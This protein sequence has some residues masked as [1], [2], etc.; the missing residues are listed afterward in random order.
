MGAPPSFDP[1]ENKLL[2]SLSGQ[3]LFSL[4]KLI[5]DIS[6]HINPAS[7]GSWFEH[8]HTCG[9]PLAKSFPP[10]PGNASVLDENHQQFLLLNGTKTPKIPLRTFQTILRAIRRYPSRICTTCSTCSIRLR[11]HTQ[12]VCQTCLVFATT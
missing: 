3:Q 7:A 1:M 11:I 10:V 8:C 4:T 9:C 6:Q 5:S 2:G 12:S